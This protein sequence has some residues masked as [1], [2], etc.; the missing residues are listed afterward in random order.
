MKATTAI[1]MRMTF[2]P[3]SVGINA[4]SPSGV[5]L[6]LLHRSRRRGAGCRRRQRI[7]LVDRMRSVHPDDAEDDSHK[8]RDEQDTEN[9]RS[10]GHDGDRSFLLV[11][12]RYDRSP[13]DHSGSEGSFQG[14]GGFSP[15]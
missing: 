12:G 7:G 3:R 5:P 6:G 2:N 8:G 9:Q 4:Q 13:P 11:T 1:I 15:V 14:K 10:N